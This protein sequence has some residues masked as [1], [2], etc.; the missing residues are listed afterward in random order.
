[1]KTY[2]LIILYLT[3]SILSDAQYSIFVPDGTSGIGQSLSSNIG[4]GTAN[5]AFYCQLKRAT[6]EVLLACTLKILAEIRIKLFLA[7][8]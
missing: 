8:L 5:P 3:I 1:M 7:L 2:I 6:L 4:V